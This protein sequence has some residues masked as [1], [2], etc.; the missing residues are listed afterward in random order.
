MNVIYTLPAGGVNEVS[1][2]IK[3]KVR[4]IIL[5]NTDCRNLNGVKIVERSGATLILR[6]EASLRKT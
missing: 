3:L 4:I 6:E 5:L 2:G 1:S